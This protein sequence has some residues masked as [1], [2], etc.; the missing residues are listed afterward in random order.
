MVST[1]RDTS[2]RQGLLWEDANADFLDS[3]PLA[4]EKMIDLTLQ[5]EKQSVELSG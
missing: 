3:I 2:E 4:K 5:T 1:Q